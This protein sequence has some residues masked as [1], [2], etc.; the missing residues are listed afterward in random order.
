MSTLSQFTCIPIPYGDFKKHI[1][2]LLKRK[3]QSQWDKAVNSKLHETHP[4]LRLWPGG[5][6]IIRR[7]ESVLA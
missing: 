4:Q 5:F 7:E 2:V 1:N 3:W 6:R